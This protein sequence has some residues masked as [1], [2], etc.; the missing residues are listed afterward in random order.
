MFFSCKT[1]NARA[2]PAVLLNIPFPLEQLGLWGTSHLTN[3][4]V[5][6][7]PRENVGVR[8]AFYLRT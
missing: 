4:R 1:G 6:V 8:G 3:N 2:R 7:D 5:C